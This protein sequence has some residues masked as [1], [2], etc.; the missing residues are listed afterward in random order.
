M[1]GNERQKRA[2]SCVDIVVV[3]MCRRHKPTKSPNFQLE[4]GPL[5]KHLHHVCGRLRGN[6]AK[7]AR[8]MRNNSI[9]N[10]ETI[11]DGKN[12][13]RPYLKM[14]TNDTQTITLEQLKRHQG[15]PP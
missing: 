11:K 5:N 8:H 7:D 10:M 1:E 9:V 3:Y 14:P 4:Q 13:V 12:R 15:T 2:Y 6:D